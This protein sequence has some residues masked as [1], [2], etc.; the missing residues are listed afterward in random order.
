MAIKQKYPMR[1]LYFAGDSP[2]AGW[3]N[4]HAN[5]PENI[6]IS[7]LTPLF[8]TTTGL[9]NGRKVQILQ[10]RPWCLHLRGRKTASP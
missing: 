4:K 7:T 6:Y 5:Q 9:L 2:A 8:S 1:N 10:A 3:L